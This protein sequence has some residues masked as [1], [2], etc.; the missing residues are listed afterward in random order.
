M[1]MASFPYLLTL[2]LYMSLEIRAIVEGDY[3]DKKMDE[4]KGSGYVVKSLESAMWYFVHTGSLWGVLAFRGEKAE[5]ALNATIRALE[6]IPG[7][8][9]W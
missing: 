4:I 2:F 9:Y 7:P 1:P 8:S 5:M 6:A 3:K